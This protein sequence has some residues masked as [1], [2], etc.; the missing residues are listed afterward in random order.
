[1]EIDVNVNKNIKISFFPKRHKIHFIL[2]IWCYSFSISTSERPAPAVICIDKAWRGRVGRRT[3]KIGVHCTRSTLT[4]RNSKL[5]TL[6]RRQFHGILPL[7]IFLS[8][9]KFRREKD[10]Q[11]AS[12]SNEFLGFPLRRYARSR[13][14]G[15]SFFTGNVDRSLSKS[16]IRN[17]TF[18]LM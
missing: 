2:L 6:W 15:A 18:M 5:R 4:R 14:V 16:K 10:K 7:S 1:M 8:L 13:I 3:L 11:G 17:V 12:T 9:L